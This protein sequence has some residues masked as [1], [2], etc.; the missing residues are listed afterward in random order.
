M[1]AV[2]ARLVRLAVRIAIVAL[3]VP[4]VLT[5]SELSARGALAWLRLVALAIVAASLIL[6][7]RRLAAFDRA[8]RAQQRLETERRASEAKFETILSIAADAIITVDDAQ[9]IVHFNR[10][11]EEIFGYPAAEAIG[12]PLT[13]LIPGR[14]SAT[15]A[16]HMQRFAHAP[17]TARRMGERREIFGLRRGGVE[18][19]A[20]ASISKLDTANG[21]LFT[22]EI[23]SA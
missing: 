1:P 19:P 11:A 4:V 3:A 9:R 8:L 22:V 23:G 12:Q 10:G 13:M 18:F 14:F 7:E 5:I 17:E 2:R 20:E 16:G 21:M 15:H 6:V